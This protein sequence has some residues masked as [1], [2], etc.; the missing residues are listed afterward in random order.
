ML[1][2]YEVNYLYPRNKFNSEQIFHEISRV[3]HLKEVVGFP[4]YFREEKRYRD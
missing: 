4:D 3:E 1:E 2:F